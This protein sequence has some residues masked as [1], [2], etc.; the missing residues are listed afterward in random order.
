MLEKIE[1]LL[2]THDKQP[3]V[4]LCEGLYCINLAMNMAVTGNKELLDK[5]NNGGN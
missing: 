3:S 5:L 2:S 4:I 1:I